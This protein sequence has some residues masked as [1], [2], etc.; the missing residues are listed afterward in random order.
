MSQVAHFK[1]VR[2]AAS[3]TVFVVSLLPCVYYDSFEP[4]RKGAL[5]GESPK[6]EG[7]DDEEHRQ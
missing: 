6:K 5:C 1:S 7:H 3:V 4:T 2:R